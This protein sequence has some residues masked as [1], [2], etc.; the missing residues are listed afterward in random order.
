[1]T[2]AKRI[3]SKQIP[4]ARQENAMLR[5]IIVRIKIII[6]QLYI[7]TIVMIFQANDQLQCQQA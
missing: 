3:S 6:I 2:E 5:I 4:V 1:V 7:I